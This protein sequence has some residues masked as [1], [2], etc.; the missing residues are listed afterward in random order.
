MSRNLILCICYL[1]LGSAWVTA[2]GLAGFAGT[3][4][5]PSGATIPGGTVTVV[6]VDTGLTRT[7]T[8][9]GDGHYVIPS[10][11]PAGYNMS[12][13]APGFRRYAQTGI[14]LQADESA[15]INV[16]LELGTVSE[17]TTVEATG[18]LQVDTTT[19][20]IRQV[21]D[22]ARMIEMPLNGR[23]AAA[24]TG[25]VAGTV[26]APPSQADQGKSKSFPNVVALSINGSLPNQTS[27]RLDGAQNID[28]L[29]N[30]NAPFPAPDA[31][32]EFSVQTSNYSAEFGQNAG[33]VVNVITKSGT[34]SFHGN[35]FGFL[36]NSVFNARNFFAAKK[37]PLKRGQWGGTV[38]GPIIRDKTFFFAEYQSTSIRNNVGGL[39]GYVPTAA[40]LAGDFSAYLSATNP[41][42]PLQ[43]VVVIRNPASGVPYP[44]NQIPANSFDKASLNVTKQ[45]PTATGNGLVFYNKPDVEDFDE[46]MGR[47]DHVISN[48]DRLFVRYF[49]DRFDY[50]PVLV[51]GNILTYASG[52]H[53]P[54]QN[55]AVRETHIFS[56]SMLNEV[57][58][59][60]MRERSLR[61]PSKNA[62]DVATFGVQNMWLP[63]TKGI[64]S[65]GASG[66]FSFG[67]YQEGDFPRTNYS[68]SDDVRWVHGRH[69]L[70]F[71]GSFERS[72]FDVTNR[73]NQSG[74]F[75]FSGDATG[76]AL[77]D[78]LLGRMRTFRQGNGR[79]QQESG[80]L[81]GLYVQDG[82]RI[83]S[84]LTLNAGVRWE[85]SLP[86]HDGYGQQS[87]FRPDLFYKGVK[88]QM[89]PNA[90][91]GIFYAGDPG[92]PENGQYGDWNN[93]APRL[94]IAYDPFGD[95]KTSIRL[96][97]G[98]FFN[99][100]INAWFNQA[101]LSE[102][103]YSVQVTLTSPVGP[104]S[105]PYLGIANPFPAFLPPPRDSVFPAPVLAVSWDPAGKYQTSTIYNWNVTIERQ[106]APNWLARVSYVGTRSTHLSEDIQLNPA[107]YKAGSTL[108][109][110]ARRIFQGYAGIQQLANDVNASY[111]SLQ[112]S[113][114][115][116][117]S[118]GLSIL[119]NYTFSKSLDGF[120]LNKNLVGFGQS[121]YRVLP[122]YFQDGSAL[123]RGPSDFDRT[124]NF[125]TSVV[126]QSP[127]RVGGNR[128]VS[129]LVGSW[130]IGG[131]VNATSGD[132]LTVNTNVDRSQTGLGRDRAVYG[133]GAPMLGPGAC[134]SA[135]PCVDYINP[136]AFALPAIG[137]FGNIAKGIF[138]GPGLLN[139]DMNFSKTIAI[140]ERWRVQL[141]GEFFN[142]F[143]KANFFD[144]GSLSS[145]SGS[146]DNYASANGVNFSAPGFGR[147]RAA[148]DPRITQL[149]LKIIF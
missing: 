15:T 69:N 46:A 47:V 57:S 141:R 123:D 77:A 72:Y 107:V 94:G 89:F 50:Q 45:L 18:V 93:F 70:S 149:A 10:L 27:Y 83:N 127:A 31:L 118:H 126:W 36:R 52:A 65:I 59:S 104:F 13:E 138:R 37:D 26:S 108:S 124:H 111:H 122:W 96:G 98:V 113:L 49:W 16:K 128:W 4:T 116:R 105:N 88:S 99:S 90:P 114:E 132:P 85:P 19:A 146:S 84:R 148:H 144:P 2:Q 1:V 38:G 60:I 120:P 51:D 136:A 135:A 137:T 147:I 24:L 86:W 73:L 100:R 41:N 91:P 33:G 102:T 131:I 71:G 44:N 11:R 32:Q 80:Y 21:V 133:G 42:N 53:I 8:T 6:E 78:F 121:S 58:F 140:K 23:N 29:S 101:M 12:V 61:G 34:N 66:F 97:G 119:A 75:N 81:F 25:L 125:V 112:L 64:E 106:V 56:S 139:F 14:T 109:V 130:G 55:T 22:N 87:V 134:Q 103:P 3:V 62:P 76:S 5:D 39:S 74:S 30:V 110:D 20:T 143:N 40:N 92:V 54:Y 68:W 48:S 35:A 115:K 82:I 63:P 129:R 7:V 79:T 95:G 43:K 9:S 67:D 145:T 142:I 28:N 17:T 117:Y